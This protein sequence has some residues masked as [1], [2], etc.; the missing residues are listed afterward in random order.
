MIYHSPLSTHSPHTEQHP[1]WFAS[2]KVCSLTSLGIDTFS[3]PSTALEQ[4]K[5]TTAWTS[6]CYWHKY[7]HP[8][9][10]ES[11]QPSFLVAPLSE[12]LPAKSPCCMNYEHQTETSC[13]PAAFTH[14]SPNKESW[15]SSSSLTAQEI[16]KYYLGASGKHVPPETF[17]LL[18]DTEFDPCI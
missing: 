5:V 14:F 11:L 13:F 10:P 17:F 8:V 7:S 6:L 16:K 15:P 2:R 3:G 18:T 4:H 9:T 12:T 1:C